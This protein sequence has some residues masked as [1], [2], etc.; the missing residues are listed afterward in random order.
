M[1]K[2]LVFKELALLAFSVVIIEG[3][4]ADAGDV[5]ML[6]VADA[7]TVVEEAYDGFSSEL[8]K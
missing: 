2:A 5:S 8:V 6:G 3:A 4:E 1:N 7:P